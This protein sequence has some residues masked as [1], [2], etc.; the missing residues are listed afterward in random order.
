M[1]RT[2]VDMKEEGTKARPPEK[3]PEP[4]PWW[5][6]L[7]E[8]VEFCEGEVAR[9]EG[10]SPRSAGEICA[11]IEREYGGGAPWRTRDRP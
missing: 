7:V 10:R 3:S 4:A 9:R 6:E 5:P 2:G 8:L 1:G 11:A